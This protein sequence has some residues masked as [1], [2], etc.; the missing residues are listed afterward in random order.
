MSGVIL[1]DNNWLLCCYK[2]SGAPVCEL[3]DKKTERRHLYCKFNSGVS[4]VKRCTSSRTPRGCA[5]NNLEPKYSI[6][7]MI[8]SAWSLVTCLAVSRARYLGSFH[9][10]EL[11]SRN[12]WNFHWIGIGEPL[13]AKKRVIGK[14]KRWQCFVV[15]RCVYCAIDVDSLVTYTSDNP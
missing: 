9:S 4:S 14:I 11:T 3:A 15:W 5:M 10:N 12:N 2:D 13:T 6:Y 1:K 7:I 8:N